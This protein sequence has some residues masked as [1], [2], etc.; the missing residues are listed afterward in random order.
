[1]PAP[2]KYIYHHE[3]AEEF[4]TDQDHRGKPCEGDRPEQ[5]PCKRIKNK[6]HN[7]ADGAAQKYARAKGWRPEGDYRSLE[8]DYRYETISGRIYKQN[9]KIQEATD[10]IETR[11]Q[12]C[13][14]EAD[15][16]RDKRISR[17]ETILRELC[18][19][20][21]RNNIHIIGVQEEEE[22]KE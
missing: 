14:T 16:E 9:G 4:D 11:E 2:H 1:M 8:G 3:K 20:S 6:A 7:H 17:N 15:A 21:K 12:A 5:S 13:M 18:D 22:K 10:G 19:Q